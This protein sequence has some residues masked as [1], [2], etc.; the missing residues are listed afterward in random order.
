MRQARPED[1]RDESDAQKGII[2]YGSLVLYATWH[3][4]ISWES[5]MK[6]QS[7]V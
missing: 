7:V 6:T 4:G 2:Q 5:V 1:Q 3:R